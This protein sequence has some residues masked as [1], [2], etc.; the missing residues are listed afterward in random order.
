MYLLWNIKK[1]STKLMTVIKAYV[2]LESNE[3]RMRSGH[4]ARSG[5]N[6]IC[7][8][9]IQNGSESNKSALSKVEWWLPPDLKLGAGSTTEE[10]VTESSASQF[11]LGNFMNHK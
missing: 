7:L 4:K 5:I 10:P 11:S 2:C 6:T 8:T 1:K 9:P 3:S